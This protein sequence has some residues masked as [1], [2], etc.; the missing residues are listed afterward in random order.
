MEI[1]E[2]KRRKAQ[3]IA[4]EMNQKELEECTFH[5]ETVSRQG[6]R[7]NLDQF[8]EDQ[9]RHLDEKMIKKRMREEE[10]DKKDEGNAGAPQINELSRKMIAERGAEGPVHNRLYDLS[11]RYLFRFCTP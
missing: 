9:Q 4:E 2:I 1:E 6:Q 7:R 5:P 10:R 8:L 3:V 11:T